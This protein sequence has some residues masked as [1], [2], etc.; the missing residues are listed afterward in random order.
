VAVAPKHRVHIHHLTPERFRDA[1]QER[2]PDTELVCWRTEADFVAGLGE[3]EVVMAFRPPRGH[4]RRADRLRFV[5]MTG[6]G[7]DALLPAPDLPARVRIAN[8]RGI[9]AEHMGE[10]ALAMMLAFE[11]RIPLWLEEQ[12]QRRWK[13]HGIRTLRGKTAAILGLGAI[14]LEVARLCKAFGMRVTGTRRS[15]AALAGVDRVARPEE[16]AEL[17]AEADYVVVLLPLTPE[18]RN[19]IGP[20]LLEVLPKHAVLINLARGGILDEVELAQRLESHRLRGAA[21]DVFAEEPLPE[22]SPLWAVPNTI[23]TPH[24]SGWFPGYAERVADIFVENLERLDR[25]EALLNEID[26]DRG[27]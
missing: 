20:D 3:A 2:L 9:H 22:T 7:V 27:Y 12:Q 1:L 18:T 25:G 13:Y 11:K 14:G 15:G 17:L 23:L 19:S 4:W 26:R 5:Q 8:A 10:F 16:T 21:L 6:A 24:I